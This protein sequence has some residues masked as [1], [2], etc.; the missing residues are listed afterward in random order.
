MSAPGDPAMAEQLAKVP[1]WIFQGELDT[2]PRPWATKQTRDAVLA[3]GG[4][5]RY[6]EYA[7]TGHNTWNRAYRENDFF[8]WMLAHS[9]GGATTPNSAPVVEAGKNNSITLPR[10]YRFFHGHGF[11]P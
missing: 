7:G 3:A 6:T 8:E 11:G 4:E 5:V 1:L 9:K 10:Q 2:N